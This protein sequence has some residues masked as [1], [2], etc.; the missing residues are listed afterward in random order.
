[1]DKISGSFKEFAYSNDEEKSLLELLKLNA[2]L[3]ADMQAQKSLHASTLVDLANTRRDLAQAK[4]DLQAL[5]NVLEKK[6]ATQRSQDSRMSEFERQSAELVQL[7]QEVESLRREIASKAASEKP[8]IPPPAPPPPPSASSVK[9][10]LLLEW[11]SSMSSM[12]F[13]DW[14]DG[15]DN[16]LVSY[17][18]G[19]VRDVGDESVIGNSLQKR[20]LVHLHLSNSHQVFLLPLF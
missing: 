1:M 20:R 6:N 4:L 3:T 10:T 8:P 2:S 16:K 13:S 17:E 9:E 7:R 18:K 19:F 11:V 14:R 15:I 12:D 5:K